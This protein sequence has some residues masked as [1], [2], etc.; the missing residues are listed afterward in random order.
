MLPLR[1]R[2]SP[3]LFWV[4]QV[5]RERTDASGAIADSRPFDLY[6]VG[7][8]VGEELGAVRSCHVVAKVEDFDIF[9]ELVHG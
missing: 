6:D 9:E 8:V 3:T 2:N 1:W 4:G 7:S 5:F